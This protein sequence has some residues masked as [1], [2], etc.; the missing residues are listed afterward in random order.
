MKKNLSKV[1][2][3][4]AALLLASCQKTPGVSKASESGTPATSQTQSTPAASEGGA[5]EGSASAST[6]EASTPAASTPAGDSTPT[7][8]AYTLGA[9]DIVKESNKD[10]LKFTGTITGTT[11]GAAV[12]M[13]FGIQH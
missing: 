8:I 9:V 7:E 11:S 10:Y 6:P 2:I 3:L 1:M 12:K 5:S 13:A 4:S